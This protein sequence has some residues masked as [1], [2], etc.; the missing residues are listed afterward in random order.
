[1]IVETTK[2]KQVYIEDTTP[3]SEN[4]ERTKHAEKEKSLLLYAFIR[5]S[6]KIPT[7]ALSWPTL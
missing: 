7:T 5:V 3:A 4:K 6:T 1:M 2:K